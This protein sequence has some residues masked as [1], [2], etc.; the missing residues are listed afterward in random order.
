MTEAAELL[1]ELA[2]RDRFLRSLGME[3][4]E[5]GPGRAVVSMMVRE[6]HLNFNGTCHGGAIFALADTAFGLASNSHGTVAAGIDAHIA[7]PAAA[8]LGDRLTASAQE[9]ARATRIATYRAE[10]ARAD[11]KIVAT[12]TGT[13]FIAGDPHRAPVPGGV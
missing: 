12:F 5:G 1:N 4:V 8:R 6:D 7:Y 2:A 11:G 9:V 10:V 13:V 3:L